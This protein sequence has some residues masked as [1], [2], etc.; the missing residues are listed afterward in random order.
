MNTNFK[1]LQ[2]T[3]R[4][5]GSS[6]HQDV[7]F[8]TPNELKHILGAPIYDVN[9]GED[10]VNI[11]WY[12]EMPDGNVFTVYDYKEYRVLHPNEQVEWHIGGHDRFSTHLA[13][14]LISEAL[15]EAADELRHSMNMGAKFKATG[16]Y[17]NGLLD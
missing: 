13:K 15:Q 2:D 12:M 17:D 10:K 5:S 1:P 14:Q 6:F 8:A 16:A 9:D 4:I 3:D 7:I 11:E